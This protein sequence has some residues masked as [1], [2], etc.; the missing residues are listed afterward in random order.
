MGQNSIAVDNGVSELITLTTQETTRLENVGQEAATLARAG[1]TE[2][3]EERQKLNAS[4]DTLINKN[5]D[6]Q[7]TLSDYD[8]KYEEGVATTMRIDELSEAVEKL[9]QDVEKL[10]S[11]EAVKATDKELANIKLSEARAALKEAEEKMELLDTDITRARTELQ[12]QQRILEQARDDFDFVSRGS[13]LGLSLIGKGI[14]DGLLGAVPK[15]PEDASIR[16][17]QDAFRT[18]REKAR[19][20]RD[21]SYTGGK[22]RRNL[23]ALQGRGGT[24]KKGVKSSNK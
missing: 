20:V 19:S 10:D 16:D 12:S 4:Y 17:A 5:K 21:T 18:A 9:L 8:R 3:N 24:R 22:N 2:D 11:D 7:L 23:A 14:Q 6:F 15:V 1:K 13:A